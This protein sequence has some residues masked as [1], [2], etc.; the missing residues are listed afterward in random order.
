VP[1]GWYHVINRGNRGGRIFRTDDD[2]RRFL[3]WL[4]ELPGRFA[5]AV[6]A[7]VLMDNHD[8]LFLRPRNPDL[9]RAIPWWPLSY[10]VRF[11]WAHQGPGHR[12]QGRFKAAILQHEQAMPEVVSVP[13][14]N[15]MVP[16]GLKCTGHGC[17]R[18]IF[19][20]HRRQSFFLLLTPSLSAQVRH[21]KAFKQDWYAPPRAPISPPFPCAFQTVGFQ[22]T[23]RRH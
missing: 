21:R 1:H 3:G 7:F 16:T 13:F 22:C 23:P 6:H 4:S 11:S 18:S 9:S 14:R 8:H 12:F 5:V 2:R 20:F 17:L 10:A 19:L 15:S